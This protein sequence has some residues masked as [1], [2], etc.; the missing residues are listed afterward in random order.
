L[1][2]AKND[3]LQLKLWLMASKRMEGA[4]YGGSLTIEDRYLPAVQKLLNYVEPP[5]APAA[6]AI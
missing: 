3:D 1:R 2:K 4:K 6:I 5:P